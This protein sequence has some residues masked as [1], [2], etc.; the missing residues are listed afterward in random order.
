MVQGVTGLPPYSLI[1]ST[2]PCAAMPFSSVAAWGWP[3]GAA[4]AARGAAAGRSGKAGGPTL[5]CS[6]DG[7]EGAPS[8]SSSGGGKGPD[9]RRDE[10]I[11]VLRKPTP[12]PLQRQVPLLGHLL[13]SGG[14]WISG[15]RGRDVHAWLFCRGEEARPAGEGARQAGSG[16]GDDGMRWIEGKGGSWRERGGG[17]TAPR[18]GGQKG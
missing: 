14:C 5:G 3:Q 12:P 8:G 16:G 13:F 17:A 15:G 9:L 6:S 18:G 4:L 2:P 10:E 11:E 7:G 1:T